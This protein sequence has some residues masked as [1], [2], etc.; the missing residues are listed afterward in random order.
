MALFTAGYEGLT[1]DSFIERLKKAK[2]AK[3]LDVR[4]YPLSR[5]AGFSKKS[6]AERLA[7]AGIDYEHIPALGCPK[8]IRNQYKVDGSWSLYTSGYRAYL[9]TQH[10]AVWGVIEQASRQHVC[11]VC[12]EADAQYCHR[13]LIAEAAWQLA[14]SLVV[15]HLP[16]KTA[17]LGDS[18]RAVA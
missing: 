12:F 6:F 3:V 5:K 1:I 13:S 8:P 15:Q 18:V 16:I 10:A 2:V 17:S 7:N 11:V 14:G 4:E 9:G